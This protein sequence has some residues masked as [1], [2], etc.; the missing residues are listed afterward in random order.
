M[1]WP[2]SVLILTLDEERNLPGCLASVAGAD[3]V[4]V[5]DSGSQDATVALA[6]AAGARVFYRRFDS[7][8]GQR[9]YAQRALAFRHRWVFHLD[10]DERFTP[11]LAAECARVSAAS[12]DCDGYYAA[13]RML[14]QGR[15]IPRCTDYPAWQARFVR[16][17]AFTFVQAGHGQR[18]AADMRMGR[19][20]AN[21]LH[22]VLPGG[23]G[24]WLA[25]HRVYARAEAERLAAGAPAPWTDLF[26]RDPL[27]RRRALKDSA[28]LV[29]FRPTA[30]FL[31][32]YG[33]RAGFLDGR[34]GWRYCRLLARYEGFIRDECRRRRGGRIVFL[35]RFYWPDETATAQL[36]TDLAE[37]LAARGRT[38]LVV[39]S[40]PPGPGAAQE[41]R[42]AVRI[43]RVGSPRSRSLGL[44]A[45]ARDWGLFYVAGLARVAR[46]LRPGDTLIALTDP[47]LVG[48]GAAAVAQ[49][50]RAR[51]VHWAQD[52]YPEIAVRVTGRRALGL[53]R[54]ARNWAWRRASVCVAPGEGMAAVIAAAGVPADRLRVRGNWALAGLQPAP[55]PAVAAARAALG[56]DGRFVVAYSGNLGRVHDLEAVLDLAAAL[57]TEPGI[58]VLILGGGPLRP[59]L[60][61]AAAARGLDAVRFG[62]ARPRTDLAATLSAADVH[63]VTLLPGC[64]AFVFPSKLYGAAAVG[65][66]V[67]F[68]GPAASDA[69]RL[70]RRQGFGQT[71]E[72][73]QTPQAAAALRELARRPELVAAYGQ[74]ALRFARQCGDGAAAARDWDEW[75]SASPPRPGPP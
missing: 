18:E 68:I 29:P 19:L 34:A 10:A 25:K 8:A 35:N 28:R 21:Y 20:T 75:V 27:R 16:A 15:W 55:P 11:E 13:P 32:Q 24:E 14:F 31:Y 74:A 69:A 65:R 47:P 44:A 30:R 23:P 49:L 72:R 48:I 46:V 12:P 38:V 45:K 36:L 66:P 51:L 40:R 62:P 6:E 5:L 22:E 7:F 39:A 71:F 58:L 50:R 3:D 41:T 42:A 63:L 60:E 67:W 43:L 61:R 59:A 57:R 4:V 9:N 1:S 64:E 52:I 33:L 73:D 26:A 17:P 70:V 37:A 56:A 53:I 54:P 2:F